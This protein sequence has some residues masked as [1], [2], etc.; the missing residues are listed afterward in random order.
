MRGFGGV[1]SFEIEG[2]GAAAH[3]F[4]DALQIPTIGPSLGGVESMV[5]PL[6]LMGYANVSPE[7]RAELG[8]RDE[9]VRLCLGI[10]DT[11]DLIADLRQALD[12]I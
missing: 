1:V 7:E 12:K 11:D 6:A 4:I 8:I 9:L 10:E 5:S 3:R 2:D